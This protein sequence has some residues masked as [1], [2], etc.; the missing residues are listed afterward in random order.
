MSKLKNG[1]AISTSQLAADLRELADSID[2]GDAP[3]YDVDYC[4]KAEACDVIV[5]R[6]SLSYGLDIGCPE[7]RYI[8]L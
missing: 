8:Y 7:I 1:C 3:V 5:Y 2:R 6:V 4:I